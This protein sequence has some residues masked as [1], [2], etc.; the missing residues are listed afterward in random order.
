M[1][2]IA[3]HTG[4]GVPF[5]M[6]G[7]YRHLLISRVSFW[8]YAGKPDDFMTFTLAMLPPRSMHTFTGTISWVLPERWISVLVTS[9]GMMFLSPETRWASSAVGAMFCGGA[10]GG[11]GGGGG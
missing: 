11:G 1:N 3:E 8:S 5:T 9:S 10:G 6:N 2:W 4:E 7:R